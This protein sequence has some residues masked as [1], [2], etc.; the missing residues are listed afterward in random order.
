MQGGLE[1]PDALR[2]LTLVLTP[3]A[4]PIRGHRKLFPTRDEHGQQSHKLAQRRRVYARHDQLLKPHVHLLGHVSR[5]RNRLPSR[6]RL[7][8][9]NA[10]GG[11]G[12]HAKKRIATSCG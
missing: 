3:R 10:R 12:S 7:A 11:I 8:C 9:A 6:V 4:L 2:V 5:P 1:E